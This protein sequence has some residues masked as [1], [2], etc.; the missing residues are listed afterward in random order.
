MATLPDNFPLLNNIDSFKK[1]IFSVNFNSHNG[2]NSASIFSFSFLVNIIDP[3]IFLSVMAEEG[4]LSF[5]WEN[6]QK[7]EAIVALGAI[8]H[9][10]IE[11]EEKARFGQCQNFINVQKQKIIYLDNNNVNQSYFFTYF[12]FFEHREN[13]LNK[14]PSATIFLPCIQLHKKEEEY[15]ITI[16]SYHN[17]LQKLQDF[18]NNNLINNID[19]EYNKIIK[20]QY[21][22]NHNFINNN[23]QEFVKKVE[24]GLQAI[25]LQ[26]LNKIVVAHA[27][28]VK[29]NHKFDIIKSLENLRSN[30]PDCYIFSVGNKNRNYFIGASPER[31][32]SIQNNQLVSDALAGSAPRSKNEEE[33]KFIGSQLLESEKE[34]REHQVVSNFIFNQLSAMGFNPKK[35]SLQ[36]LKLSHIQHLWTP[37]YVELNAPV[38]PLEIV[39]KLHPT[40]AVAGDPIS[41]ACTEIQQSEKFDRTLYAAP[42]GW[43][44]VSGNCEFIVGIRSALVKDNYACLY[45]GAGIVKGSK[46]E[47]ELT[48]IKLKFQALLQSLA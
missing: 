24:K 42:I 28:E 40:P 26:Q 46:P 21:T 16:N 8:V 4:Q 22:N 35:A 34:K 36:L 47:Q 10:Q 13:E 5:Y 19:A 48:E 45:A 17:N 11:G 15:I 29:N 3:L 31:L 7:Q 30:H 44:D 41:L 2:A 43:L 6:Q 38:N 37:I 9:L 1:F 27:L 39:E 32:L 20:N 23:Y 12:N 18:I 33:D 14:F 25:K